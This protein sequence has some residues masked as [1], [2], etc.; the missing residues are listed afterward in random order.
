VIGSAT[1]VLRFKARLVAQLTVRLLFNPIDV[2]L[3]LPVGVHGGADAH[4]RHA[5]ASAKQLS[6]S[7]FKPVMREFVD[8]VGCAA[9][10]PSLS[11]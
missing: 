7:V 5:T 3:A 10:V 1:R 9:V 11:H 2:L 4:Q 8:V 6:T